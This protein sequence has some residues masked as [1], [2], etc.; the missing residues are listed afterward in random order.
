MVLR[1]LLIAMFGLTF[2]TAA[3]AE[4]LTEA[5]QSG[6]MTVVRVDGQTGEVV[7]RRANA[8]GR[9]SA[10]THDL[11]RMSVGDTIKLDSAG[12]VVI[13]RTAADDMGSP[14]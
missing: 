2:V 3:H 4:G 9:F 14:E 10:P 8:I 6:R 11:R 12:A 7:Y 1:G 5:V 13:L